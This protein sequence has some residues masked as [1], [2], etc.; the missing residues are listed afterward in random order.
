MKKAFACIALL[1]LGIAS[2]VS[3]DLVDEIFTAVMEDFEG[4]VTSEYGECPK[5][6]GRSHCAEVRD[7]A[8]PTCLSE[9]YSGDVYCA[10]CSELL[11]GGAVLP[12]APHREKTVNAVDATCS[13][14]G[15][16]GD[17]VCGDCGAELGEG[18]VI[19]V[20][21]HRFELI[22]VKEATCLSEG[23]GGDKFCIY[24]KHEEKGEVL[25]IKEHSYVDNVCSGCG[26]NTPGLYVDGSLTLSW[27]ELKA[28]GAVDAGSGKL[29]MCRGDFKNGRL[30]IGEDIT[31][32]AEG[33]ISNNTIKEIFIPYTA[34]SL[35]SNLLGG[36]KSVTYVNVYS[37]TDVI[38]EKAFMNAAALESIRISDTVQAIRPS[39]FEGCGKLREIALPDSLT[40]IEPKAFAKCGFT[41]FDV[42]EG[43]EYIG[44]RAF[45][46]CP[47]TFVKLPSTVTRMG[48]SVFFACGALTEAD[49]SA[50]EKLSELPNSSFYECKALSSVK[51]P[52]SMTAIGGYAFYGSGIASVELPPR[53]SSISEYC[54]EECRALK[55]VSLP[56]SAVNIHANA[57][58]GSF[59]ETI[60]AP[61]EIYNGYVFSL[62]ER[63][64]KIL[65]KGTEEQWEGLLGSDKVTAEVICGY[66]E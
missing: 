18:S 57:F 64:K 19:G 49:M 20:T 11:E 53:L 9:G 65:Y 7:A 54:F 38:P 39:A 28:S 32:I 25:P 47:I 26:W 6:N 2:F 63:L 61:A 50:C 4:E 43:V 30:V 52:Q 5:N 45:A 27:E 59:V 15:Y 33:G 21:D 36:N 10:V 13:S 62:N 24:C 34:V 48:A 3:C 56:D 8:E 17:I 55:H 23:F 1:C 60:V 51:L 16:S 31:E 41:S 42:P 66:S 35:A 44:E 14:E 29:T 58:A 37:K 46:N 40:L 22:Y 12:V